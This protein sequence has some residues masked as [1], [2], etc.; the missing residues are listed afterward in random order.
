MPRSR[1]ASRR[2][3]SLFLVCV[4]VCALVAAAL[5]VAAPRAG[6]EIVEPSCISTGGPA[7]NLRGFTATT[8]R[9]VQSFTASS[10]TLSAFDIAY[11]FDSASVQAPRAVGELH[12]GGPTGALLATVT[13][14]P[15]VGLV[16]P[17]WLRF[18]FSTV[19][20]LTPGATYAF[21]AYGPSVPSSASIDFPYWV[22]CS[23]DYA[24]GTGYF[25]QHGVASDIG[26]D[27][28]FRDRCG[29][30]DFGWGH[31]DPRR[32]YGYTDTDL[33][34]DVVATRGDYYDGL[35]HAVGTHGDRRLGARPEC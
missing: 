34:G 3:D 4:C 10:S 26:T 16:G 22:T 19:Q 2:W 33:P 28:A 7:Y 12:A 6:A 17:V 24:G 13:A 18:T 14:R 20:S 9:L 30:H 25:S 32:R 11:A 8:T 15:L 31:V 21:V 1:R 29:A 27:F 5:S 23:D 35:V